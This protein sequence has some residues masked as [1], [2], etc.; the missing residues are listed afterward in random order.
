MACA[1]LNGPPCIPVEI[2]RNEMRFSCGSPDIF[3]NQV[4]FLWVAQDF[5]KFFSSRIN[6]FRLLPRFFEAWPKENLVKFAAENFH[7]FISKSRTSTHIFFS[8]QGELW[9]T[10]ERI[11]NP[12]DL[13]LSPNRFLGAWPDILGPGTEIVCD[14]PIFLDLL[15]LTCF[16]GTSPDFLNGGYVFFNFDGRFRNLTPFSGNESR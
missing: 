13:F 9:E 15:A 8:L 3:R 7:H 12:V 14:K 1:K 2:F 4:R 11:L 6:I 5:W 10:S 16:R